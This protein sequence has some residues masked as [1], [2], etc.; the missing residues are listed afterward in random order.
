MG[1]S[2]VPGIEHVVEH[3]AWHRTEPRALMAPICHA[4]EN[5]H[6]SPANQNA[7]LSD[8]LAL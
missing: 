3:R 7:E 4:N 2:V 5:T 8:R 1:W 6:L